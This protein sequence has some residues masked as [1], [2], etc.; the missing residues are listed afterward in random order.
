MLWRGRRQSDNIE[1]ARGQ[2]GGGGFPG[3]FGR[4]TGGGPM[5]IPVGRSSGGFSITTIIIL[6]VLYFALKACGIDPLQILGDG[7]GTSPGGGTTVTE[8]N[9]PAND[10]MKQFVATILAET[11]DVWNGIFKAQG[12][13]YE[14][15]GKKELAIKTLQQVCKQYPKDSHASVAH[16]CVRHVGASAHLSVPP[17]A[18]IRG[19][20]G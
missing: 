17:A 9:P 11:E 13:T 7:T 18:G 14:E 3:G 6:V 10:E 8:T 5:R 19:T 20:A 4:N 2:S 16:A 1:D 12:L 15:Q